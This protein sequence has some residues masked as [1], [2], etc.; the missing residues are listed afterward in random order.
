[1]FKVTGSVF[2]VF[3]AC[4][5]QLSAR[6]AG[7]G[8]SLLH[9][10]G[11]LGCYCSMPC[12]FDSKAVG[13]HPLVSSF[14]KGVCHLRPVSKQLAPSWDLSAVLDPLPH[15]PFEPLD[16]IDFKVLSF[17]TAL[18]L[19]LASAKRV[20][21]IHAFSVHPNCL[22]YGMG[23]TQVVLWPNLAFEN[24]TLVCL[25]LDMSAFYPPPFSSSE[26]EQLHALCPVH[27]LHIYVDRTQGFCKTNQLFVSWAKPHTGKPIIKQW[28]SH[29]IVAAISMAY[30]SKGLHA[31]ADLRAHSTRGMATSWALFSAVSIQG[32]CSAASSPH[33][34][35]RFYAL[36]VTAPPLV[37][38]VL[39][40]G[41][42]IDC[43]VSAS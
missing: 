5:S 22:Q 36:D 13:Q 2:P 41:S 35:A 14:M 24:H 31:P 16:Q 1:M 9:R 23:D 17:K 26:Q 34:F 39:S 28:L 30:S 4:N 42:S 18:L 43:D 7:Q 12:R 8:Q 10:Q 20:S 11:I 6:F 21:D 38:S 27:A 33:T 37:H 25:P 29:W 3:G 40:V 19:A 15:P 32:I